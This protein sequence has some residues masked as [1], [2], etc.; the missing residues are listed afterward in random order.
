M[1]GLFKHNS[2][3][4]RNPSRL[5]IV[6]NDVYLRKSLRRQFVTEG[7]HNIF[8]VGSLSGLN[9]ALKDAKPDLIL[10][11]IQMP[12]S[13]GLEICK[14]LRRDGYTK[15]IVMLTAKT[16]ESDIIDCLEAGANDY[17][18]KPLR[19]GELLARI[20][21]QLRQ[22][23]TADIVEFKLADL[24]FIP[25]K[26]MLHKEGCTRMQSL[27]EKETKILQALHRAFPLSATKD[28]LL[29]EVWGMRDGLTTH[30]LETHIYRLRQKMWQLTKSPIVITTE[31]GYRLDL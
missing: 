25:A 19:I 10:L 13:N 28:E 3:N 16:A 2:K 1:Q 9:A 21:T 5:L 7:F 14:R 30:T 24:Y 17:V 26:K 27:T 11:D 29:T 6:D 12:D 8:D 20:H 23:K 31:N 22:H 4:L 18:I 15:P